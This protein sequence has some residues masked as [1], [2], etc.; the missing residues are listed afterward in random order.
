MKTTKKLL[1]LALCTIF[2][3]VLFV[4]G[5]GKTASNTDVK[6]NIKNQENVFTTVQ[7]FDPPQ[8]IHFNPWGVPGPG[9]LGD[10][11]Y[12]RLFDYLPRSGEFLPVLAEKL[13]DQGNKTTVHL[14]SG[15]VW[16]NGKAFTSKDVMAN[17]Y[18]GFLTYWPV[19][20]YV[21]SIEATDDT[22]IV[23]TWKQE[24]ILNKPIAFNAMIG[25][26]YVEYSKWVDQVKPYIEKRNAEGK[27]DEK[28]TL[29]LN[30]IREDLFAYKP[31][32]ENVVV[33]GPFIPKNITSS[34][35]L[36]EKNPKCFAAKNIGWDKVK[37]L[38]YT[39]N[40]VVWSQLMAGDIDVSTDSVEKDVLDQIKEK[41]KG[42]KVLLPSDYSQFAFIYNT[43][44]Y[45]MS[46]VK[47]RKALAYAINKA[48]IKEVSMFFGGN[49]DEYLTGIL[50]S[51]MDKWLDSTYLNTLEKFNYNPGKAEALLKE[52]GW[53]K[54][55]DGAWKDK[56][57]NIVKIELTAPSGYNEWILAGE[58]ITNQLKAFGLDIEFKAM[59]ENAFFKYEGDGEHQVAMEFLM[60]MWGY[61]HPW[62]S[63]QDIF[64]GSAAKLGLIDPKNP[65]SKPSLKVKL[66]SGEEVDPYE[67]IKNLGMSKNLEDQK[68][69]VK[70]L[71]EASNKLVLGWPY[72][73]K[74]VQL[75]INSDRVTGFPEDA[76]DPLYSFG[77]ANGFT[78]VRLM[79]QG[80]LQPKK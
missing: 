70:K 56:S 55:T 8:S 77:A 63:Y 11:M 1:A 79:M 53:S 36:L 9:Q 32:I 50:P 7:V 61:G 75:L 39:G 13:E 51:Q 66:T 19:W 30:A 3:T 28:S 31:G 21:N 64:V 62:N 22:T 35:A 25:S 57:G 15:L 17:F 46:D 4:T 65:N 72:A 5:C 44:K 58:A 60:S 43:S 38:R 52:M 26:S 37:L 40:E 29:E 33:I 76:N 71:A 18:L 78:K 59:E 54:G 16:S 6:D 42:M 41:Q 47:F 12:L 68:V 73:E 45:P 27:L 10:Y 2:T 49:G 80:K 34:E 23:F 24:S 67:L 48:P 74:N 14:R 69:I 20:D